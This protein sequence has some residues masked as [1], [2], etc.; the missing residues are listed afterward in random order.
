[1]SRLAPVSPVVFILVWSSAFVAVRAGLPDVSPLYFLSVRF[2]L[3]AAILLGL[4]LLLYRRLPTLGGNW[5]HLAV[6]GALTSGLYLACGYKAMT[7]LGGAIFALIGALH[8]ILVALA[9]TRLLGDRFRPRQWLGFVLGVLGVA[10]VAGVQGADAASREG[11]AFGFVAVLMFVCGTLYYAR[12]CRDVPLLEGNAV[13]FVSAA[14]CA[15][16]CTLLFETPR[17]N[18]TPVA[19]VT[20]LHLTF[21]VSLG[22]M[23][24]LFAMLRSGTAGQVSANFYL[25]PGV[26]AIMTWAI[27]GET[28]SPPA[29]AGFAVASAGVWL[30]NRRA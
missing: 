13:Q 21:V 6:V 19:V 27:L 2:T 16:A 15:W 17:A 18:W 29:I 8:P 3:A 26:T 28:L 7:T 14:L 9:S 23:A 22:G 20:L 12:F 24:L 10:L 4:A 30:V 5:P 25:T 1:M 11:L